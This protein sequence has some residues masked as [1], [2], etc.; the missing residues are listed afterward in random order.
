MPIFHCTEETSDRAYEEFES[1]LGIIMR[2]IYPSEIWE[3][4]SVF[5]EHTNTIGEATDT[6]VVK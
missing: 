4:C 6:Y 3:T 1:G 2:M 5:G